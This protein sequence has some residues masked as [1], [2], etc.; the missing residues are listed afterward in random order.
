MKITTLHTMTVNTGLTKRVTFVSDTHAG[1][2]DA[3]DD[4][5]PNAGLFREFLVATPELVLVGDILEDYESLWPFRR[6]AAR[7]AAIRAAYPWLLEAIDGGLRGVR[8][9]HDDRILD[10]PKRLRIARIEV[11][12]GDEAD[13]WNSTY[14]WGGRAVSWVASLLE[15]GGW[16]NADEPWTW[17]TPAN[18][19]GELRRRYLARRWW[20]WTDGIL[21]SPDVSVL[22][23][24]HTHN[25]CLSRIN[26]G[27]VAN[28]GTWRARHRCT[29][30]QADPASVSLVEIC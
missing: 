6:R 26:A 30:I 3:A 22:V 8:G 5:A 19:V 9:N 16:H 29:A 4:F 11:R 20:P 15:R 12:H 13:P 1:V 10:R 25:P 27:V 14:R 7:L 18:L 24:G 23:C 28:C 2:G 21:A 17:P